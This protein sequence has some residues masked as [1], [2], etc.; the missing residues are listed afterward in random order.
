MQV[1]AFIKSN[2]AILTGH[3]P[4]S[5]TL[6]LAIATLLRNATSSCIYLVR[7]AGKGSV[8]LAR[9]HYS[10]CSVITTL[11][12]SCLRQDTENAEVVLKNYE[13]LWSWPEITNYELRITN[14]TEVDPKNYEV[15][16]LI[17]SIDW[18]IFFVLFI[19][20]REKCFVTQ[21]NDYYSL[22]RGLVS[23]DLW[24]NKSLTDA[25]ILSLAEGCPLLE[26]LD[27][28]WW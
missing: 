25:G 12:M 26:E 8:I 1:T 14:I 27:I 10:C 9:C 28:G 19:C 6:I 22:Y 17:R 18:L 23:L 20:L 21:I 2:R 11:F 15:F 16:W 13:Y 7:I 4:V 3:L 5:S 24:R